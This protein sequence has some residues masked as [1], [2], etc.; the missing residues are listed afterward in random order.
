MLHYKTGLKISQSYQ[1][2]LEFL[3]I[4]D[5]LLRPISS[6]CQRQV[7]GGTCNTASDFVLNDVGIQQLIQILWFVNP[8]RWVRLLWLGLFT[9]NQGQLLGG[10]GDAKPRLKNGWVGTAQ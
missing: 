6:F 9:G 1:P 10:A 8:L 3:T 7:E 4:S 5:M 2:Q